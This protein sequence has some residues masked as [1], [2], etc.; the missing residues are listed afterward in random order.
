MTLSAGTHLGPYEILAPLGAGGMGEV[1]KA[2]D[3]RLDRIVAVKILAEQF[4]ERFEREARAVPALNHPNICT[5]H[6]VGPNC[7]VMEY[8]EG[9]TLAER[10]GSGAI[11]LQEALPIAR[12]IAEALEAAHEKGIV[13]RDLKPANIKVTT[14]GKVKVLDFGLAKAFDRKST[15]A[16]PTSSPTLTLSGTRA[17]VIL[18]TAAYMSPEQARGVAANKRADL[19]SYGVVLFEMLT[20][21]RMFLGETVSDT[22]AAVLRADFDWTTLPAGTPPAIRRLLRR[23]LER[24]R[25]KRL[26]DICDARLEINEA[27]SP[28]EDVDFLL[29]PKRTQGPH[30]VWIGLFIVSLAMAVGLAAL[31]LG[32][33]SPPEIAAQVSVLPPEN[34]I[35][36][37]RIS[38]SPDG[39]NLAFVATTKT[40]PQ[41]IYLRSLESAR[42]RPLNGSEDAGTPFWSPDGRFL[43]FTTRTNKLVK[44]NISGGPPQKLCDSDSPA[45]GTWGVDGTILIGRLGDVFL[46]CRRV[47][48]PS[49]D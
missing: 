41:R 40:S 32:R 18:G 25:T 27:L 38:V 21:R 10:I 4:S 46:A 39:R 31:L 15:A 2:R 37:D 8:I 45:S 13:H 34:A 48:G 19:W 42:P 16:D 36:V 5:L 6:D 9:P 24:D 47:T 28:R 30:R 22:L 17:G 43:A 29:G 49:T 33:G 1:Y 26:A 35:T 23:C 3:T 20:G 11:P 12:Q 14:D 7:L 44:V